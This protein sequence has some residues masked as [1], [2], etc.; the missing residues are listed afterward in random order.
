MVSKE[1]KY[2]IKFTI[3]RKKMFNLH[4]NGSKSFSIGNSTKA[5]QFKAKGPE[6]KPYLFFLVNVS[7]DFVVN[8]MK[9]T[10][11]SRYMVDFS[12]DCNAI[13]ISDTIGIHIYSIKKRNIKQCFD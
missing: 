1:A 11:L 9:K 10:G 2:S 4:Y 8:N 6:I 5:Y 13:N 12:I 3:S 7:N